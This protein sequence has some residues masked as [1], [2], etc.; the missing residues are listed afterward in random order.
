[1]KVVQ[2]FLFFVMALAIAAPAY[3]G[4][5]VRTVV[6]NEFLQEIVCCSSYQKSQIWLIWMSTTN[7][8]FSLAIR[9]LGAFAP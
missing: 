2:T 3:G 7:Y 8:I 1:M 9:T 5:T 6:M 4:G